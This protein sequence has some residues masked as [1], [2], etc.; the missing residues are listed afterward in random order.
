MQQATILH[1]QP[2]HARA[3]QTVVPA[4]FGGEMQ[5]TPDDVTRHLRGTARIQWDKTDQYKALW[6]M[7]HTALVVE[8]GVVVILM[9]GILWRVW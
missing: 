3:L 2:R 9:A 4:L 6:N 5:F 1:G 8:L 7:Y